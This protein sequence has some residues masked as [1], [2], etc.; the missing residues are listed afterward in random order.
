MLKLL[1]GMPGEPTEV[2]CLL[3]TDVEEELVDEEEYKEILEKIREECN[4]FGKVKSIEITRPLPG[5][6]VLGCGKV[7]IEFA[8]S[9]VCEEAKIKLTGRKFSNRVV[10]AGYYNPEKYQRMEF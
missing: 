6:E 9:N 1:A 8:T 2:L 5:V 10:V 3:N 4:K 7:F